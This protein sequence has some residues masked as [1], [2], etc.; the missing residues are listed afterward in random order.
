MLLTMAS[1]LAYFAG[2][3]LAL[4]L[5]G[6][7]TKVTESAALIGVA[8]G[9]LLVLVLAWYRTSLPFHRLWLCPISCIAA[10]LTGLAAARLRRD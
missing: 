9:G 7:L 2:P 6:M 1:W 5:L 3:M 4:F 10:M 8:A